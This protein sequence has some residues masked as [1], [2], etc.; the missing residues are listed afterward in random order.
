MTPRGVSM[1]TR[2]RALGM[3]P[4]VRVWLDAAFGPEQRVSEVDAE[5]DAVVAPWERLGDLEWRELAGAE[6][7]VLSER[8]SE[9]YSDLLL[10]IAAAKPARLVGTVFGKTAPLERVQEEFA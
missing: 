5:V 3:R 10:A 7:E 4:R 8:E 6:V 1:L 2:L 9:R